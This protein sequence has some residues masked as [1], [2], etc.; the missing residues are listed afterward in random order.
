MFEHGKL[1]THDRMLDCA[2]YVLNSYDLLDGSYKLHILWFNRRGMNL[3][4]TEYITINNEEIPNWFE[5]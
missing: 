5:L 3:G 2:V 1:Y 4:I